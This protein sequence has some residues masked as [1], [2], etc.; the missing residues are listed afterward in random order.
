M[1][2]IYDMAAGAARGMGTGAAR[3]AALQTAPP[4]PLIDKDA[5][6]QVPLPPIA[7]C[8]WRLRLI[9][10]GLLLMPVIQGYRGARYQCCSSR[11]N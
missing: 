3:P 8:W 9:P 2:A 5:M 7:R 6:R 10:E 11:C 4:S 1:N